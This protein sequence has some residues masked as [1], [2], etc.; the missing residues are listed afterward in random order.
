MADP[1]DTETEWVSVAQAAKHCNV[2][3]RTVRNWIAKDKVRSRS[4]RGVISVDLAT[5]PEPASAGDQQAMA[6]MITAMIRETHEKLVKLV[7]LVTNNTKETLGLLSE[8]NGDLRKHRNTIEKELREMREAFDEMLTHE[9]EREIAAATAAR[10]EARKDKAIG[11]LEQ[12][13]AKH[14]LEG[15]GAEQVK[16]ALKELKGTTDAKPVI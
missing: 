14:F 1:K 6:D 9:Q 3:D 16:T 12:V 10:N 13:A 5:L 2:A 11:L 4:Y 7:E 8:E 15:P